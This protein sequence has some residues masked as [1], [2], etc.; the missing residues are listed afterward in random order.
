[1]FQN[2]FATLT[3]G[4]AATGRSLAEAHGLAMAQIARTVAQQASFLTSL[5]GFYYL[6]GVAVCGGIFAAWQKQI[7]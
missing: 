1:M 7:D 3:A 5:D 6:V 2:A 4:F